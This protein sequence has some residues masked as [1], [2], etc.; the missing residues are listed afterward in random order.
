MALDWSFPEMRTTVIQEIA[1]LAGEKYVYPEMG[2]RIAAQLQ[3]KLADGEYDD[4]TEGVS[5]PCG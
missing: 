4:V 1:R 3:A 5:W 2:Q